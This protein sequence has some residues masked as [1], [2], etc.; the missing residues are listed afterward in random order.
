MLLVAPHVFM[1][2][3]SAYPPSCLVGRIRM[4]SSNTVC[5]FACGT[6]RL[7]CA[8]VLQ[9]AEPLAGADSNVRGVLQTQPE[10]Q[11]EQ[12]HQPLQETASENKESKPQGNSSALTSNA[13][14]VVA[15]FDLF[16][17]PFGFVLRRRR[18]RH[19]RSRNRRRRIRFCT[20]PAIVLNWCT[21]GNTFSDLPMCL[22]RPSQPGSTLSK[23]KK[24]PNFISLLA[25]KL[26]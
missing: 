3:K 24:N 12:P 8:V 26:K 2:A 10:A 23:C 21:G 19:R 11:Q 16:P 15:V 6:S 5:L 7:C 9:G 25:Q 1:R 20:G 22:C 4:E 13:E 18:H 14:Q 17:Q